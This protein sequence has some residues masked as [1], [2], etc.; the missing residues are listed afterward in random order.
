MATGGAALLND[1]W[2]RRRRSEIHHLLV[3]IGFFLLYAG[4][5]AMLAGVGLYH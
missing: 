5:V 3:A 2:P 4:T 1:S